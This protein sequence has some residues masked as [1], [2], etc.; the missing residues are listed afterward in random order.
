MAFDAARC[1]GDLDALKIALNWAVEHKRADGEPLL[2]RNPLAKVRVQ[3]DTPRRPWATPERHEALQA[4]ADKL[5]PAFGVV[6]S[7]AW[8][9]GHRLGAILALKWRDI[10]FATSEQCPH[11]SIRWYADVPESKKARDAVVPMNVRA[12]AA[13]TK[14]RQQGTAIGATWVFPSRKNA[15][16]PLG[17]HLPKGWLR[18]AEQL[19]KLAHEPGGGWHMM[20]RGWA[21]K[22]KGL[23]VKDVMAAGGWRD[24]PTL[25]RSY[26][27]ADP[28]TILA[29][30][31]F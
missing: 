21:T 18:R 13:L 27:H 19:A 11:G 22:R 23:S 3:R 6:L 8:Q 1:N 10:D 12:A 30:V 24:T 26:M 17:H 25:I 15:T 4:V 2:D 29:V 7:V 9:T 16:E 14:W 31:N 20:R 5:P 28:E